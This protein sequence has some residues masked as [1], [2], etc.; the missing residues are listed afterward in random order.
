MRSH[1]CTSTRSWW[2]QHQNSQPQRSTIRGVFFKNQHICCNFTI[3]LQKHPLYLAATV[4]GQQDQI[5]LPV[6][7]IVVCQLWPMILL[8]ITSKPDEPP[9]PSFYAE[10]LISVLIPFSQN[11]FQKRVHQPNKYSAIEILLKFI[12]L[13]L[14]SSDFSSP[15]THVSVPSGESVQCIGKS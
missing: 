5:R 12:Q 9:L 1:D 10:T 4:P 2:G 14:H 13:T 11:N 15:D 6:Y 8:G 7:D 3:I